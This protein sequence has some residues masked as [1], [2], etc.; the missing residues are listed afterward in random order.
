MKFSSYYFQILTSLNKFKAKYFLYLFFPLIFPSVCNELRVLFFKSFNFI[1]FWNTMKIQIRL[2]I[3][4]VK[5]SASRSTMLW[6]DS[7]IAVWQS[8]IPSCADVMTTKFAWKLKTDGPVLVWTGHMLCSTSG[9]MDKCWRGWLLKV[10]KTGPGTVGTN[11]WWIVVPQVW[12]SDLNPFLKKKKLNLALYVI[13]W[14]LEIKEKIPKSLS[15][16]FYL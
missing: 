14:N 8:F 2:V 16:P 12:L 7:S 15:L 10:K 3:I 13:I 6:I 1:P 9:T 5:W 4:F 11:H